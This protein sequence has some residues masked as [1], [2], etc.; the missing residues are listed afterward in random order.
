MS[1]YKI[2]PK[3]NDPKTKKIKDVEC[4]WCNQFKWW[5]K[6]EKKNLMAHHKTM[7]ELQQPAQA[8]LASNIPV[9]GLEMLHFL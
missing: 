9:S 1:L 7:A 8:I 4:T 5:T 6:G 2:P 3:E